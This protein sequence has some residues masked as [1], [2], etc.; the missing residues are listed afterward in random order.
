MR[1]SFNIESGM[2]SLE[3]DMHIQQLVIAGW[4]G[5]DN[6]AV[7]RHIDE[8]AAIGVAPP[9]QVPLFYRVSASQVTQSPC[10][11]VVGCA[12]SGEVEPFIFRH[13]GAHYISICSDHTDRAIEAQSVCVSKQMC[14][15]PVARHAWPLAQVLSHWDMLE[16]S[17]WVEER[18]QMELYQKGPLANILAPLDLLAR[19]EINASSFEDGYAMSCGTLP[20]IGGIRPTA[21]FRM[22]L[23][24]PLTSR[25]ICHEY[26]IESLPMIA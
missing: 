6:T 20:V 12:S 22:E 4:T 16:M 11:Q 17:S 7:Q 24:D 21:K 19:F 25:R 13:L 14:A 1:L 8:L 23:H 5:R 2:S 9:S 15:K 26:Q 10:I 18:G 3:L